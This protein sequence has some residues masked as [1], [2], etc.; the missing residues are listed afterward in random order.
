MI[1]ASSAT[2]DIAHRIDDSVPHACVEGI[3]HLHALSL[4]PWFDTD[5]ATR[6]SCG[7]DSLVVDI[8]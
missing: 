7:A 8:L 2:E 4:V 1:D 6:D 3:H 5:D